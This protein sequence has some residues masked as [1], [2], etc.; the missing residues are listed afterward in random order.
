MFILIINIDIKN[1][2]VT[3]IADVINAV[4]NI[5]IIIAVKF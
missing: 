4:I 2:V 5:I 3:I 1:F